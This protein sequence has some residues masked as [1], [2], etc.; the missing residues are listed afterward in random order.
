MLRVDGSSLV[1]SL[2]IHVVYL[3]SKYQNIKNVCSP[4]DAHNSRT[5]QL[6]KA[7]IFRWFGSGIFS[8][9]ERRRRLGPV[10]G[11][12]PGLHR[13]C[14]G[15]ARP[16]PGHGPQYQHPAPGPGKKGVTGR[17][18]S[19]MIDIKHASFHHHFNLCIGVRKSTMM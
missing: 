12:T 1:N 7:T 17:S 9:T 18:Y 2:S 19:L 3:C 10:C 6:T 4:S 13:G 16:D 11:L 5:K 15:H 8:A 14:Q